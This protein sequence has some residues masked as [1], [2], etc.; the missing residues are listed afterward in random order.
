M[1]ADGSNARSLTPNTKDWGHGE[2]AVAPDGSFIVYVSAFDWPYLWRLQLPGGAARQLTFGDGE[3]N[4]QISPDGEWLVYTARLQDKTWGKPVLMKMPLTGSAATQLT[5]H[6][7]ARPAISPDGKLL[8]YLH[9]DE[10]TDVPPR[11]VI[12]PFAGGAP[13]KSFTF[14]SPSLVRWS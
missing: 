9:W 7:S 12:I 3:I 11:T 10:Q 14:D 5:S 13:I 1:D 4:P 2:V 6:S 8:A